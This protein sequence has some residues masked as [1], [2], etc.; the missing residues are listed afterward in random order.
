MEEGAGVAGPEHDG[1]AGVLRAGIDVGQPMIDR[2]GQLHETAV[3]EASTVGKRAL[4]VGVLHLAFDGQLRGRDVLE[5]AAPD[6]SPGIGGE[7]NGVE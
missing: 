4:P 7:L 3:A 6:V 1:S 5:A 2:R